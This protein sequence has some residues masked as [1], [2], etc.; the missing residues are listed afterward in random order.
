MNK[1]IAAAAAFLVLCMIS[2]P[3]FAQQKKVLSHDDYDKW[4]SLEK[5]K[6]SQEA[7]FITYEINP[8]EG[9]GSLWLYDTEKQE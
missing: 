7:K 1:H 5:S 2:S 9:D 3:T 6:I 8:Q 4:N